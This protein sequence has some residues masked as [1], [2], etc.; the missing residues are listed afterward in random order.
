MAPSQ[1]GASTTITIDLANASPGG[2]HPWQARYGQCGVETDQ[3]AFGPTDAY[4]PLQIRSDGRAEATVSVPMQ[5][6]KTGRYFVVVRAST[7]NSETVVACGNLA[8]PTQ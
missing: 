8:P 5:T 1:D 2:L 6:P 7:A 4:R 3:G